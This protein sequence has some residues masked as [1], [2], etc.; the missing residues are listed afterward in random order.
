LGRDDLTSLHY[1]DDQ[2]ICDRWLRLRLKDLKFVIVPGGEVSQTKK[3][4]S[5]GRAQC[6]SESQE[7]LEK[8]QGE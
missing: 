7:K 1:R 4:V 8:V 3:E 6:H 2:T 5:G